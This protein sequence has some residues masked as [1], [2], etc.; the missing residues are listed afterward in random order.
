MAAYSY[1]A[2]DNNGL[3]KKGYISAN[4]ERE[5][6]KLIKDLNLTPL[7]VSHSNAKINNKIKVKNKDIVIMTRQLSTLLDASTSIDDSLKITAD[8]VNDKNLSNILYN[9][10]EDIIQGKRLGNSMKSYP[11]IFNKTYTSLVTAGDSSGNLDTIF[12]NLADYLEQSEE[13]KQKVFSALT[14]PMILISFSILVIVA[15]LAFVLPQVVGQFV[16]SGTEL[17]VLTQILL[18]LSNNIFLILISIAGISTLGYFAYKRY[19]SLKTN[20]LN[21]HKIILNIP[22]IGNFILLTETERFASTMS[23]LLDSGMNLDVALDESSEVFRNAYLKEQIKIA[24][25]EVIEGKDFVNTLMKS[26][27]FP[28][29][30]IQLIASGYKSGK[31][32]MMFKKVSAFLKNEIESK[33]SIFLSLLEPIVII[34]MG[35]FIM[36]IVLAILLPIMQMNTLSLG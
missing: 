35:G 32:P 31:L 5:A 8:Q 15:L 19:C 4:S 27:I 2:F 10:R 12:D 22:L 11:S 9:I 28:D 29:I 21:A 3:K 20:L 6:R 16:K 17:P 34:F 24:R 1:T 33:R 23:L 25:E 36:L 26:Q 30:F 13:I 14:Y 18:F 7:K